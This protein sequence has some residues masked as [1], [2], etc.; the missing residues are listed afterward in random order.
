LSQSGDCLQWFTYTDSPTENMKFWKLSLQDF[1]GELKPLCDL[2]PKLMTQVLKSLGK[3][4]KKKTIPRWPIIYH[5]LICING[6]I[7]THGSAINNLGNYGKLSE[8]QFFSL[9]RQDKIQFRIQNYSSCALLLRIEKVKNV[10]NEKGYKLYILDKL[11]G[12]EISMFVETIELEPKN[13]Q[14]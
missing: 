2:K 8:W 5:D 3:K 1:L 14:E 12:N 9:V 11:D 13:T 10:N 4:G 7:S 6:L